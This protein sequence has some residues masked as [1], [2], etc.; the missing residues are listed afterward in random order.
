MGLQLLPVFP[1]Y[2]LSF[3]QGFGKFLCFFWGGRLWEVFGVCWSWHIKKPQAWEDLAARAGH[4]FFGGAMVDGM[5]AAS[6]GYLAGSGLTHV[7]VGLCLL[8]TLAFL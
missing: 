4:P 6:A 3:L 8:L 2:C 7:C 5:P 1:L